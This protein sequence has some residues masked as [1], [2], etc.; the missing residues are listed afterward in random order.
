MVRRG[1]HAVVV[2][3]VLKSRDS[4]E[5]QVAVGF[6]GVVAGLSVGVVDCAAACETL[7]LRV[8]DGHRSSTAITYGGGNDKAK[9]N[10]N[11]VA[12]RPH[13]R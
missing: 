1:P 13:I 4:G 7:Y 2:L 9:S 3:L 10:Q 5:T 8:V 6:A 12:I 11:V